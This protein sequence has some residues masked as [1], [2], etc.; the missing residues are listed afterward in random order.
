MGKNK[1][2]EIVSDEI[3]SENITQVEAEVSDEIKYIVKFRIGNIATII[4]PDIARIYREKML[5][6]GRVIDIT[7]E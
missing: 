2:R 6:N 3:K 7:G 1:K 5:Q 4:N